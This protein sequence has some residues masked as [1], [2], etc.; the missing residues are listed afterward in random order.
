MQ[1][2][3]RI[4]LIIAATLF[5]PALYAADDQLNRANEDYSGTHPAAERAADTGLKGTMGEPGELGSTGKIKSLSARD[6]GVKKAAEQGP[7]AL[8][9]YIER[10]RG[11]YDFYYWDYAQAK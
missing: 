8:R 9:R 4:Q 10:T 2:K 7:D 11:I 5:A 3:Q 1:T 6:A